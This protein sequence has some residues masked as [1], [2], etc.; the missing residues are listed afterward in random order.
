MDTVACSR[1]WEQ[2]AAYIRNAPDERE[3]LS[4]LDAFLKASPTACNDTMFWWSTSSGVRIRHHGTNL[5][6]RSSAT[7]T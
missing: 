4:L 1:S 2:V 6:R 3:T 7:S 5:W